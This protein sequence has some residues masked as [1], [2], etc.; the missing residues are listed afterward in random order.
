VDLSGLDMIPCQTCYG[1][2]EQ[3]LY[4]LEKWTGSRGGPETIVV[5]LAFARDKK[6]YGKIAGTSD[7]SSRQFDINVDFELPE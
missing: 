1:Q 6:Y 7:K 3:D 4:H 2:I 5:I